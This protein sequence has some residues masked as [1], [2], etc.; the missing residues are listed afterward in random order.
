MLTPNSA[1]LW[2][3]WRTLRWRIPL[4]LC[5]MLFVPALFILDAIGGQRG[6]SLT[7]RLIEFSPP[8]QFALSVFNFVVCSLL[9]GQ[10][11]GAPTRQFAFPV[12]NKSL[13]TVRLFPGALACAGLYLA[14][15]SIVNLFCVPDTHWSYLSPAL[16][17]GVGY[18]LAYAG[19]SQFHGNDNRMGIAGLGVGMVLLFW[20]GGHYGSRWW[21]EV[22]QFWPELSPDEVFVL[23]ATAV[24]SW[25]SLVES[26]GR[27]RRGLGRGRLR[28]AAESVGLIHPRDWKPLRPF[29]SP[30]LALF[31]REWRQDGWLLP[32]VMVV[33]HSLLAI[34]NVGALLLHPEYVRNDD[35]LGLT[36]GIT[37]A[38]LYMSVAAPWFISLS[39]GPG[40]WALW[41]KPWPTSQSTLPVSDATL[42]GIVFARSLA[43][44][45][46]G[47]LGII[48]VGAIW[49][50]CVCGVLTAHGIAPA[51]RI[52]RTMKF[53]ELL[54]GG[55]SLTGASLIL[56]AWMTS[57]WA[58]AATLSGRR[59]I[60]LLPVGCIPAM[61]VV[62]FLSSLMGH[63]Q[64]SQFIEG[65]QYLVLGLL[66]A[67]MLAAYIFVTIRDLL[68]IKGLLFGAVV[69]II[70]EVVGVTLLYH[71]AEA[72]GVQVPA[73]FVRVMMMCLTLAAAPPALIPLATH[74]NR[75]R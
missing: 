22:N 45:V 74:F 73:A 75:H 49:Y 47:A 46:T 31:W 38:F 20:I 71:S 13:A 52:D 61:I 60:A 55:A 44:T 15:A 24:V 41:Q 32:C 69:L 6:G 36:L 8:S 33:F 28:P 12:T 11:I 35:Q 58:T 26:L 67:G 62:A 72:Q 68:K 23:L 18:M 21:V 65:V 16:T 66:L 40:K 54:L 51:I 19:I 5:V 2:E 39:S 3:V 34:I 43:S 14:F 17:Y 37:I 25:L 63:P 57:G 4:A 42:G 1:L 7:T 56:T 64:G 10:A 53:P 9:I 59:W 30:W 27:D 50:G 29:A 70:T 48:L